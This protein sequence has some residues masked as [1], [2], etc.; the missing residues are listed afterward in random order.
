MGEW[1]SV[2]ERLPEEHDSIFERFY[3]TEK[4]KPG[5]FRKTS[6]RVLVAVKDENGNKAVMDTSTCDGKWSVQG[7]LSIF[8]YTVTHWMP[9]PEPPKEDDHG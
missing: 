4:W 9:L 2:K 6:V 1:I 5:M 3:G 8:N 7:V